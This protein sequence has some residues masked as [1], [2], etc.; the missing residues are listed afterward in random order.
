MELRFFGLF[1]L[2][3]EC[4]RRKESDELMSNEAGVWVEKDRSKTRQPDTD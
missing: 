2:A 1:L 4:G 3:A